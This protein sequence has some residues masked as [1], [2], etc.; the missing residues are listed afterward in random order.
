MKKLML[1]ALLAALV[2]PA[3][4]AETFTNTECVNSNLFVWV[5]DQTATAEWTHDVPDEALGNMTFASLTIESWFFNANDDL[6]TVKLNDY[7]LGTMTSGT[8]TFNITD[9]AV[10]DSF[11]ASTP[12]SAT[13]TFT[14]GCC[15]DYL[16]GSDDVYVWKSTLYGEFETGTPANIVP[17]PAPGAILLTGI[18][19]SL[20]GWLRRRRAI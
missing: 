17:A 10:L 2:V 8:Q 7:T 9:Q 14:W 3:M 16:F 1:L 5:C 12:A 11:S 19:T 15:L 4:A 6:V 18:G 13:L 20:V